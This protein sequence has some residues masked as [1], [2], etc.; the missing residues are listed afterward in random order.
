MGVPPVHMVRENLSV[1]ITNEEMLGTLR[2]VTK[3]HISREVVY[4]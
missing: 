1:F 4:A 2:W 3:G